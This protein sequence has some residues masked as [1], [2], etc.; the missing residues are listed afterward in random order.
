[1]QK[2]KNF[3]IDTS[4]L[5]S[6]AHINANKA[7]YDLEEWMIPI[8]PPLRGLQ[9]LDLGCGTGKQI[10]RLAQL[11]SDEG[12]ILGVD[13]SQEAVNDV[14]KRAINE[15]LPW[16]EVQRMALDDCLDRLSGR[17]FDLIISSYAI[18]Y[19]KN[20]IALL[21][22]LHSLLTV[23]GSVFVCGPAKGT[24]IE[25]V[26]LVNSFNLC[27]A[28]QLTP[29]GDFLSYENIQEISLKYSSFKVLPLDNQI[30]FDNVD[31]VMLWWK[32]H[33]SFV[34]SV[35]TRVENY[36]HMH[37]ETNNSFRLTKN[38]LGVRFDA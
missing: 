24:N 15:K 14:S 31:D 3:N 17:R 4:A 38:V 12:W 29:I 32:H 13:V 7:K 20:P 9:V 6:R 11:V 10:F 30:L 37:F 5:R 35:A 2:V 34:S 25:I 36:L 23:R 28:D 33:N 19:S 1:M 22:G 21:K 8:L 16:I 18:Y 26:N 27:D